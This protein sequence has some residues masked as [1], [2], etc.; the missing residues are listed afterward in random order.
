MA[1]LIKAATPVW[2]YIIVAVSVLGGVLVV[3]GVVLAFKGG[4]ASTSITLFGNQF[5]STSVGIAV[6]FIGAVTIAIVLRR[7]LSSV[8]RI[9]SGEGPGKA[10][11]A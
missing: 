7:I 4:A 1:I 10:G 8:D 11:A 5:S 9:T 3:G 6:A 2:R